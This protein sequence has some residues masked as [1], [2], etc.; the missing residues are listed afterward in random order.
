M[1]KYIAIIA[2]TILPTTITLLLLTTPTSTTPFKPP[3]IILSTTT[4]TTTPTTTLTP[5]CT[6]TTS[7]ESL[8]SCLE[9][10]TVPEN[11]YTPSSYASAQPSPQQ[12]SDWLSLVRQLLYV[13]D[14]VDCTEI[15]VPPSI[16]DWYRVAL[17]DH[18]A[19]CVLHEY[20]GDM[21]RGTFVKGWGTFAVPSSR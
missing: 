8:I 17:V 13:Q 16:S 21:V 12:K 2:G 14:A 20:V 1:S 10:H 5:I 6:S 11:T 3:P 18:D 15:A 19:F 7:L 4:S 9:S